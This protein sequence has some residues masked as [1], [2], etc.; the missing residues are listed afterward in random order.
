MEGEDGRGKGGLHAVERACTQ[1]SIQ[2]VVRCMCAWG[3]ADARDGLTGMQRG[4]AWG[5][6]K[7]AYAGGQK[8]LFAP[9]AGDATRR[10]N[11]CNIRIPTATPAQVPFN[12]TSC[13]RLGVRVV[14]GQRQA[15]GGVG[16]MGE[17]AGCHQVA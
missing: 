4:N 10:W 1:A 9:V 11:R 12:T 15:G 8:P 17:E 7:T 16:R 3:E 14:R 13:C 2:L 6:Q 5:I